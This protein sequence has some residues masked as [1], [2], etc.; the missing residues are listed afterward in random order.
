MDFDNK[1]IK[2]KPAISCI[3]T[4]TDIDSRGNKIGQK[5]LL[6]ILEDVE[7]NMISYRITPNIDDFIQRL[8]ETKELFNT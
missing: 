8:Q 4:F 5:E 1:S 6:L 7:G 2:V 3:R